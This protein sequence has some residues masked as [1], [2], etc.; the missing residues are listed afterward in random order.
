MKLP[1]KTVERLSQYRRVLLNCLQNDKLFIYSHELANMLHLTAVQVRRDIMLIGYASKQKKGYDVK[2]LIETIGK[3][4][5]SK[6][7]LNVA[8][9]GIGNLGKAITSYFSGK[10]AK[11]NII[12]AFDNDATKAGKVISGVRCYHT[13]QLE[14]IIKEKQI[15]IAVLTVPPEVAKKTAENLV[16]AGIKG[17]LNFTSVTLSTTPQVYLEEYDMTTSV[18]KVAYFVKT[19]MQKRQ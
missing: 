9:V 1:E 6:D 19:N 12:A 3:I 17:I 14:E 15:S 18:E 5:D 16:I 10:R 8:V 2:E 7:A 13:E 4:I 11:L